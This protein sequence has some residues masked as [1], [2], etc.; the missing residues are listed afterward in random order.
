MNVYKMKGIIFSFLIISIQYACEILSLIPL[1]VVSV[2][3]RYKIKPIQIGLGPEPLIINIYHKKSLIDAGYSAE[4]FVT[5]V[6]FITEEFDIRYD[7]ITRS[8]SILRRFLYVLFG[9]EIVFFNAIFRYQSLY[10]YFN[11]CCLFNTHFLWRLEP[12]LYSLA[13]VRTVVMPYGGD[14]QDL[15]RCPNLIFRHT[16]S[17]SYPGHRLVRQRVADKIDLWTCLADHVISGLDWVDYM[18]YWD[19]LTL[20]HHSID[21]ERWKADYEQKKCPD[22][23]IK[24]LHAPN[25]REIKGSHFFIQAVEELQSEGLPIELKIR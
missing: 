16:M 23:V 7:L 8:G 20:G 9:P 6:N 17:L 25:H 10:F 3:A 5:H 21:T 19:T 2:I 15:T 14:V 1:I 22:S 13:G 18:Y 12:R 11:G 24:I 4:T